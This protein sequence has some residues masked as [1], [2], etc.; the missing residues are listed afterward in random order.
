[1]REELFTQKAQIFK[2]MA[3]PVRLK[4][5]HLLANDDLTSGE[6]AK[7]LQQKESNTSRHLWVLK[8]AGIVS[9]R[10][11]GLR[12]TYKLEFPCIE[13][14]SRCI[15]EAIALKARAFACLAGIQS[16]PGT[17]NQQA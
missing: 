11:D 14:A 15:E 10:K 1:M 12:I 16:L 13:A 3:H 7:K 5:I 6:L 4:I 17:N 2:A 8:A 9:C